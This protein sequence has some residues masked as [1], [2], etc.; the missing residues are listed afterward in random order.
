MVT[1]EI[2]G[3]DRAAATKLGL[4]K[5]RSEGLIPCV[6]YSRE[7]NVV[8]AAPASE[9]RHIVYTPDFKM[10]EI[11]IGGQSHRCILKDI[12]FDP[13]TDK[14][15]HVDFLK[16]VK[17]AGLKVSVPLRLKGAAVGVK[18]GGKLLQKMKNI[19]IKTTPEKLVGEMFIDISAL[20]LGQTMRIRDI[21]PVD[22]VQIVNPP[23]TPV[24]SVEIPRSLKTA[25]AEAKK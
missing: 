6:L 7:E 19:V 20:D 16:M 5:M 22:G 21:I 24:V 18:S 3:Q 23:A 4:K 2:N 15:I 25:E 11:K 12:Q 14:V 9:I 13:I 1:V 10:A 8:F 17:G